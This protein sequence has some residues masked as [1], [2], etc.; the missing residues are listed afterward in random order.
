MTM[1]PTHRP[2]SARRSQYLSQLVLSGLLLLGMVFALPTILVL[3]VGLL[4]TLVAFVVDVHPRRFA[5]R[6]VAFLNLAGTIPF[7]VPLWTR[8]NT[9]EGAGKIL[10][11]P[12]AWLVMYSA[13]GMGWLVFLGMPGIAGV[14]MEFNARRRLRAIQV[15]QKKLMD[16]WGEEVDP[17]KR[18]GG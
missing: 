8:G 6:S 4:P 16:E 1:P 17:S 5:A 11:D 9:L 2:P 7:L 18:A 12:Y 15:R 14:I 13:A 10:V 3:T